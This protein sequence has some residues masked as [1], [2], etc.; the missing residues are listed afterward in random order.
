[1]VTINLGPLGR[2][3]LIRERAPDPPRAPSPEFIPTQHVDKVRIEKLDAPPSYSLVR[4]LDITRDTPPPRSFDS[5]G[6]DSHPLSMMPRS[7]GRLPISDRS[8]MAPSRPESHAMMPQPRSP[9]APRNLRYTYTGFSS[10]SLSS[11][12]ASPSTR[13][14]TRGTESVPWMG[15]MPSEKKTNLQRWLIEIVALY[16]HAD[17]SALNAALCPDESNAWDQNKGWARGQEIRK[18]TV[19]SHGNQHWLESTACKVA[20]V[21]NLV[22]QGREPD[23]VD[24]W[25]LFRVFIEPARKLDPACEDFVM[26]LLGWYSEYCESSPRRDKPF[27]RPWDRDPNYSV[28]LRINY[29]SIDYEWNLKR[30]IED[31]S[32]NARVKAILESAFKNYFR[33]GGF[34]AAEGRAY[35]S[36]IRLKYTGLSKVIEQYQRI[37]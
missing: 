4:E 26:D 31:I 2:F 24:A 6:L 3:T 10:P 20:Q 22:Q 18:D 9:A 13:V 19:L 33:L 36:P 35:Y 23:Y 7:P 11:L 16:L 30:L 27:F 21:Q 5:D 14:L 12:V 29:L 17:F 32:L 25:V 15:T 1:M 28:E 8:H 37:N 34:G